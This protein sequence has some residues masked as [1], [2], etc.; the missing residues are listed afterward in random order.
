MSA[1]NLLNRFC[2]LQSSHFYFSI[3]EVF[4]TPFGASVEA[5]LWLEPPLPLGVN[6]NVYNTSK[7]FMLA[8]RFT[9]YC[10]VSKGAFIK[11][12]LQG[13]ISKFLL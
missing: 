4:S 13:R 7:N 5:R 1:I 3:A 12:P 2:E 8:S 6:F 10:E 11:F 9:H